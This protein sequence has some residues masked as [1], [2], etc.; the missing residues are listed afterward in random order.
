MLAAQG[1]K[2]K[3]GMPLVKFDRKLIEENGFLADCILVMVNRDQFPD[4]RFISGMDAERN[5]TVI[6]V[7]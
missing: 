2:V 1:T 7:I 4:V 5:E 3:Q 6:A